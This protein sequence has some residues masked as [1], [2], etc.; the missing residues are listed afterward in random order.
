MSIVEYPFE[1]ELLADRG[2]C[3]FP[4]EIEDDALVLFHATSD[5]RL[6]GIQ[7]EGIK[8]GNEVG[9]TLSTISYAT[10]SSTAFT[11][12]TMTRKGGVDGVV[13]ALKFE[14][15]SEIYEAEGTKRS[16]ALT[17]QPVI[18]GVCRIPSTY[19]HI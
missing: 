5:D 9:G 4:R 19:R 10:A 11:H 14:D 13:L 3:L 15:M 16:R 6:E 18:I 2:Y 8:P 12:W 7:K 1:S 17:R